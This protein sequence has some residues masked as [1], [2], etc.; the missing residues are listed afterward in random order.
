MAKFIGIPSSDIQVIESTLDLTF[1]QA[2][3][4]RPSAVDS[5]IDVRPTSSKNVTVAAMAGAGRMNKW[6][7]NKRLQPLQG[8][9]AT[10]S[11]TPFEASFK[12]DRYDYNSSNLGMLQDGIN[13]LATAG[14]QHYTDQVCKILQNGGGTVKPT[15]ALDL[16]VPQQGY[17]VFDA[18]NSIPLFGTTHDLDPAGN[19]TN[20]LASTDLTVAN[21]MS[22]FSKMRAFRGP[23]SLPIGVK[24]K[25]LVVP[26]SL[27]TKAVNVLNSQWIAAAATGGAVTNNAQNLLEL[28]C[29]DELDNET[30]VW[31]VLGSVDGVAKPFKCWEL[32]APHLVSQVDP[33]SPSNF[34]RHE[35]EYSVEAHNLT[36]LP[37]WFTAFK[38]KVGS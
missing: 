29:I 8:F 13:G 12:V 19:Q 15:G 34:L 22:V 28:V 10:I 26:S 25:F 6:T 11:S 20:Y 5:I 14:R 16:D 4:S 1:S 17:S 2:L 3:K 9:S 36:L 24:P 32:E 23:D 33:T 30:D 7:T 27:W 37:C 31:Y 38:L 35:F 18:T 21:V